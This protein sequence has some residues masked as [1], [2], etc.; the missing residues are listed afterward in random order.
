MKHIK[1][2]LILPCSVETPDKEIEKILYEH[3]RQTI[4][5]EIILSDYNKNFRDLDTNKNFIHSGNF[6]LSHARNSG[7][8]LSSTDWLIFSDIDTIY[9]NNVFEEMIKQ[10]QNIIRGVSRTDIE[11]IESPLRDFYKCAN[12]PIIFQRDYFFDIG[13]YCEEFKTYGYEDS[14]LSHK[15]NFIQDFDSKAMHILSI[16]KYKCSTWNWG[17]DNNKTIFEER[18]KLSKKERIETDIINFFK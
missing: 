13:G 5:L 14:D 17:S 1:A 2:S 3:R 7:A 16:H 10:N 9:N 4:E 15:V 18:L 11:N 6:N 12:S 8:K